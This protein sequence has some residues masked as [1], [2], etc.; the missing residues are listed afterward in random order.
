MR[1]L[2]GRGEACNFD[3]RRPCQR[4]GTA[5]PETGYSC[6]GSCL[7]L[8]NNGTCDF[9]D[10]ADCTIPIACN[11]NPLATIDDGSCL[12]SDVDNDGYVMQWRCLVA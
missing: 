10:I 2:H 6:G 8:N 11:Y 7:D 4:I 1:R 9:N 12:F 5:Y 3:P